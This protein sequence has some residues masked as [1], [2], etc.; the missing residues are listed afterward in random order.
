MTTKAQCAEMRRKYT[1]MGIPRIVVLL[2]SYEALVQAAHE[3][4]GPTGHTQGCRFVLNDGRR[5]CDCIG[6]QVRQY[7]GE[8]V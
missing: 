4:L 2:D 1:E 8:A 6:Q 5:E 3:E 7:D